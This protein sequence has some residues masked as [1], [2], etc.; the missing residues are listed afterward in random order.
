MMQIEVKI[1]LSTLSHQK[2]LE[3]QCFIALYQALN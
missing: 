2:S 1:N 3:Y